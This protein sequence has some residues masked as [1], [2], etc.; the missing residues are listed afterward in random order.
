MSMAEASIVNLHDTTSVDGETGAVCSV[1]TADILLSEERLRVLWSPTNLE[2][3]A[4]TYW[5]FLTR[6]TLGLVR[7]CY[8]ERERFVVLLFKPLKLLTFDAPQ[9]VLEADRGVIKWH[10]Q[11]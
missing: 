2:R 11:R 9:Y 4:R 7:V 6:A 8:T 10:I 3:L 1:Q 5:R